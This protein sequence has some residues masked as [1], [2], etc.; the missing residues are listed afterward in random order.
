MIEN[1]ITNKKKIQSKMLAS[2]LILQKG[3]KWGKQ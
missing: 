3:L 2:D 1:N